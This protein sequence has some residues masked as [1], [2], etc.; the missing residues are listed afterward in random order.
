MQWAHPGL[1]ESLH[2]FHASLSDVDTILLG[3]ATYQ[4]LVRKW[5]LVEQWPDVSRYS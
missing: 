1:E 2:S 4:D 3:R 5:P